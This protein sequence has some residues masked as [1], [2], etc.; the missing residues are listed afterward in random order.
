M[1][2]ACKQNTEKVAPLSLSAIL[3]A[4]SDAT[5]RQIVYRLSQKPCLCTSFVDLGSKTKLSYH[6][7]QLRKA[8]LTSTKKQGTSLLISLRL[9]EVEAA[10]PGLLKA[11]LKGAS[12]ESTE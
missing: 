8:G 11:I 10:F 1:K 4:M 12:T 9:R 5:R 6:Y 2:M 3:D 7:A